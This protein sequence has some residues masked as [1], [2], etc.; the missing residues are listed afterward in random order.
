MSLDISSPSLVG[1]SESESELEE[2]ELLPSDG[3]SG[4]GATPLSGLLP[5]DSVALDLAIE[6][7]P[8]CVLHGHGGRSYSDSM[9]SLSGIGILPSLACCSRMLSITD[10][11]SISSLA[12]CA[13]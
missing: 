2:L 1:L 5:L 7:L 3:A 12:F 13:D 11:T 6:P 8:D 4:G 9:S 10:A